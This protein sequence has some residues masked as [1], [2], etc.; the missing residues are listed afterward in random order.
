[1]SRLDQSLQ[2]QLTAAVNICNKTRSKRATQREI[3]LRA[4]AT[5]GG[6]LATYIIDSSKGWAHCSEGH[7]IVSV[8]CLHSAVLV[9]TP[10]MSANLCHREH[11]DSI[12][13]FAPESFDKRAGCSFGLHEFNLEVLKRRAGFSRRNQAPCRAPQLQ[14]TTS[15]VVAQG[16]FLALSSSLG[17]DTTCSLCALARFP[18]NDDDCFYYCKK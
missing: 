2:L 14:P 12:S 13:S 17:T 4:G 3:L 1:V 16:R 8:S 10:S 15:R 6:R 11:I 9:A 18:C 5:I 7:W